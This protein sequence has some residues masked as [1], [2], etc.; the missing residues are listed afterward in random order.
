MPGGGLSGNE[1]AAHVDGQGAVEVVEVEFQ[2]RRDGQHS[3]VV[4]QDVQPAERRHGVFHRGLH[5][6]G[7]GAVSLDGQGLAAAGD[8]AFL[9][10]L[11]LCRGA[12]VGE[13]DTGAFGGQAFDDGCAD[14]ARSALDQSHFAVEASLSRHAVLPK[15]QGRM[16]W[17]GLSIGA[18]LPT[19]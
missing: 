8:D 17:M 1:D 10:G 3:G 18:G 7:I 5:G 16:P 9:Q 13:G 15:E 11:G 19:E 14:T 12:D 6:T 2:Q 4:D